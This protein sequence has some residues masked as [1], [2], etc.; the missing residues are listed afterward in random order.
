MAKNRLYSRAVVGR[1]NKSLSPTDQL[2]F[3]LKSG[4]NALES[5]GEPNWSTLKVTIDRDGWSIDE[6]VIT[7]IADRQE[8]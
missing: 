5:V 1:L 6:H 7:I 2:V 8:D 3:F 4:L